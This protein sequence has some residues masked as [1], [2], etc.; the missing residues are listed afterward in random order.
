M[1]YT[2][3][4]LQ[5]ID[6]LEHMR[7]NPEM[8]TGCAAP[9]PAAI[10]GD[11]ALDSLVLGAIDTRV[12]RFNDW[13]IISADVDWLNAVCQCSASPI[14]TFNRV[15]AFPESAVNSTR[16]EILATAFAH[17]VVSLSRTDRFVVS[18]VVAD[19]DPVW[20]YMQGENVMRSVAFRMVA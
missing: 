8:Y 14:E 3:D 11:I 17:C 13:W 6:P 5:R 2:A 7:A 15:L 16:H 12:F 9:N 19:D 20:G 4:D 1:K 10:A 18:G